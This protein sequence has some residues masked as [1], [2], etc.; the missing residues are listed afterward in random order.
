[1]SSTLLHLE[2]S[3]TGRTFPWRQLATVSPASGRPLL[4][5]YDLERAKAAL[6]PAPWR[7]R[8]GGL[9]RF[10]ELL[11]P[12]GPTGPVT[13]GEGQTPMLATER[14]ARRLGVRACWCKDESFNPTGS[15][16]ARGMSVAVTM[17]AALGARELYVPTAGNAGGALAAYAAR[18]GLPCA[19]AMPEDS[20]SAN[21]LEVRALAT[22]CFEVPGL[23]GDAG[24][25][26]RERYAG[27][28]GVFDLSTLK[29][30]YRLEGKKTMGYDLRIEL[31]DLPDVVV[32]PA[33][34][35]TGLIGMWKAFDEM[36]ALGWIDARRPRLVAVQMK[37]CA[38]IVEGLLAGREEG[39]PPTAPRTLA[40]GLRVPTP[41]GDRLMLRALRATGGTALAVSDDEML[42]A[43]REVARLEG[44]LLCP[45]G[46][47]A[48]AGL[49]RLREEG[50]LGSEERV[51]FFNT[52]SALK[53][54]EVL[55]LVRPP[56]PCR[57]LRLVGDQEA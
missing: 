31:G 1:M 8:A 23:I 57:P 29:E 13:L 46:A 38:P 19:V 33:G 44:L 42:H 16:K 6:G 28:E 52:G 36:Q 3:E 53:Y 15:F 17:A 22:E 11:P 35:G 18:A 45:E 56:D 34:G 2:C 41:L 14:L 50:W 37:S 40:A 12:P 4:A 54:P 48:W 26:L 49:L 7:E 5:R 10:P 32:Y 39:V 47:A 55:A 21:R 51:V 27:R 25:F 24:R 30:P 43:L 20:P 9:W